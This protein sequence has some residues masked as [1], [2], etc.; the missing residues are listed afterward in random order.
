MAFDPF[1]MALQTAALAQTIRRRFEALQQQDQFLVFGQRGPRTAQRV[2]E[3]EQPSTGRHRL[4]S[5]W[6]KEGLAPGTPEF[7]QW[8]LTLQPV[9]DDPEFNSALYEMQR[10]AELRQKIRLQREMP[11]NVPLELIPS[12]RSF[13]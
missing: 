1:R 13:F 9:P 7:D 10:N 2:V 6:S 12:S 8:I 4:Q 5:L 11:A 3:L